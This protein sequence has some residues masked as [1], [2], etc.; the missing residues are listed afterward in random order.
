MEAIEW[1]K[2][3]INDLV[4]SLISKFDLSQGG[5][6]WDWYDGVT[7]PCPEEVTLAD[8]ALSICMGSNF[9]QDSE[10]KDWD[11]LRSRLKS[12]ID[13]LLRS[14]DTSIVLWQDTPE[15]KAFLNDF[16]KLLDMLLDAH[17]WGVAKLTKV[18]HRKR[19]PL[20]PMLD[21]RVQNAYLFGPLSRG[22]WPKEDVVKR[23][24]IK[25]AKQVVN[26]FLEELK[27]HMNDLREI[28]RLAHI[29]EPS[30]VPIDIS[31][32]RCLEALVYWRNTKRGSS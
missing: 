27:A 8:C 5:F 23:E 12:N 21:S 15:V 28:I 29:K 10:V 18:L 14:F 32:V 13:N 19:P 6:P 30:S 9:R 3:D 2:I 4:N 11:T 24:S 7:D 25:R 22:L 17:N 31:P 16:Q 1:G 26:D 20:I